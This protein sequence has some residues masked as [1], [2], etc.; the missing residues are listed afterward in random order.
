VKPLGKIIFKGKVQSVVAGVLECQRAAEFTALRK[1][2]NGKSF[3][4]FLMLKCVHR[5]IHVSSCPIGS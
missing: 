3:S 5:V 1:A 4:H 2:E